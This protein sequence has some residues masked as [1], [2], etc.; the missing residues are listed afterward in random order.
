[1]YMPASI[2]TLV[3]LWGQ[4]TPK[5][6]LRVDSG[7]R[8]TP[9]YLHELFW[10]PLDT[11][12]LPLIWS[13]GPWAARIP[14][15]V[16]TR[17]RG[18][19]YTPTDFLPGPNTSL[20]CSWVKTH[21]HSISIPLDPTYVRPSGLTNPTSSSPANLRHPSP[22]IGTCHPFATRGA[23][24]AAATSQRICFIQLPSTTLREH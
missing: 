23:T 24:H 16:G 6:P 1:M 7:A 2:V 10:G 11:P 14:P 22:D 21:P 12:V 8:G 18:H 4:G 5:Y 20:S 15:T 17:V 3:F 19:P 9:Q 13:R